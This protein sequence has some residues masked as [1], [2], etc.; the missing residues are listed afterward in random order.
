LNAPKIAVALVLARTHRVNLTSRGL[1]VCVGS[2]SRVA[3]FS[4]RFYTCRVCLI[5]GASHVNA[6]A[7]REGRNFGHE[8]LEGASENKVVR[9]GESL[10][11]GAHHFGAMVKLVGF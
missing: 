2:G 4:F 1:T 7:V 11:D 8:S 5:K 10:H 3:S 6:R 9:D